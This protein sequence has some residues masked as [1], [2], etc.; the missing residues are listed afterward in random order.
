MWSCAAR[1]DRLSICVS[2]LLM[3]VGVG[4]YGCS[5]RC[6]CLASVGLSFQALEENFCT[7]LIIACFVRF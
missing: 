5:C 4:E 7:N 6:W 1:V 2:V 3:S